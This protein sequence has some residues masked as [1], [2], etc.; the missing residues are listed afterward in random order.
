MVSSSLDFSAKEKK[1]TRIHRE[2]R[3]HSGQEKEEPLNRQPTIATLQT[4]RGCLQTHAVMLLEELPPSV[5]DAKSLLVAA[6]KS[7][8]DANR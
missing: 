2:E 8:L 5:K 6:R 4:G 3:W 7:S 1:A